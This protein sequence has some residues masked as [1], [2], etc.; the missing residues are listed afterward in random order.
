MEAIH[1]D[2]HHDLFLL[3]VAFRD[4]KGQ[5]SQ[6]VI[7]DSERAIVSVQGS[8]SPQE[9][10]EKDR[11]DPLVPVREDMVLVNEI[12]KIGRLFSTNG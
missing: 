1:S 7:R 4:E 3:G 8:V 6:S 11:G 9:L 12:E 2:G 10:E 5:R